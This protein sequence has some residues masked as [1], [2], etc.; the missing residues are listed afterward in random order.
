M[1]TTTLTNTTAETTNESAR[2]ECLCEF[3]KVKQELCEKGAYRLSSGRISINECDMFDVIAMMG[4]GIQEAENILYALRNWAANKKNGFLST[5]NDDPWTR[6]NNRAFNMH[7]IML[8]LDDMNIRGYQILYAAEYTDNCIEKLFKILDSN[9][10][11]AVS[12]LSGMINYINMKSAKAYLNGDSS[13]NQVAVTGGASFCHLGNLYLLANERTLNM[14]HEYAKSLAS[15]EVKPAGVDY[16]KLDIIN[17]V[18]T[19][20]AIRIIESRGFRLIKSV[21][22][23]Q[24]FGDDETKCLI[25]YNPET[26]DY[27][28]ANSAIPKNINYGGTEL[29]THRTGA[30]FLNCSSGPLEGQEGRYYEFTHHDGLFRE[31]E[32][33]KQFIPKKDYNWMKIGFGNYAVPVPK[34][35]ELPF[36]RDS[37]LWDKLGDRAANVMYSMGS[38]YFENM[39]NAV[40]CLCDEELVNSCSPHYAMYKEWFMHNALYEFAGWLTSD[41]SDAAEIARAVFAWLRVPQSI[42][43]EI[44]ENTRVMFAERDKS[45]NW[46]GSSNEKDFIKLAKKLTRPSKIADA[47][48]KGYGLPD[49]SEL[50]VK[51]SWL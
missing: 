45:D 7:N 47:I 14:D 46:E 38:F 9:N 51:L 31:W 11:D 42:V 8:R 48:I 12:A 50:P 30:R 5:T 28:T 13:K 1:K 40:L 43:D 29:I 6:M 33:T 3:Q 49:P 2:N 24:R 44:V 35:F 27:V 32:E 20:T 34:Y 17:I 26:K 18:D 4:E 36:I 16:S 15:V 10:Q 37:D 22:R 25:F 21:A 41:N 23:K 19:E 39:V